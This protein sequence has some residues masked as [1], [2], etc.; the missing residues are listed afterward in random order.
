LEEGKMGGG[1]ERKMGYVE[2]KHA[3]CDGGR[4]PLQIE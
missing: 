3:K 1:G 4:E 2:K